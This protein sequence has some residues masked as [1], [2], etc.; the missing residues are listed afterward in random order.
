MENIRLFVLVNR[1][2][3][4]IYKTAFRDKE[5]AI[6]E[7]KTLPSGMFILHHTQPIFSNTDCKA[8]Y[9][10]H[11][12]SE[13]LNGDKEIF[14]VTLSRC[15]SPTKSRLYCMDPCLKEI[16]SDI[17][18]HQTT[19]LNRITIKDIDGYYHFRIRSIDIV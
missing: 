4:G 8:Y 14:G 13:T 5:R 10:T 9:T 2:G 1:N 17:I 16:T 7:L 6:N 12:Y 15:I 18:V 11:L 19:D 3:K